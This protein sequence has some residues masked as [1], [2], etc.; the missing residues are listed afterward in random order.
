[1]PCAKQSGGS[2]TTI[3]KPGHMFERIL[4]PLIAT[5]MATTLV[6]LTL[7]RDNGSSNYKATQ[8]PWTQATADNP[9]GSYRFT[10]NGWEESASWRIG[11]EEGKVKFIDQV[12]PL[13]WMLL[14]VLLALG[15]AILASD[16]ETVKSLWSPKI[17]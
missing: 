16:E 13:T 12:H 7:L 2:P 5:L 3:V 1:M 17:Q 9:T 8:P 14:V 6:G 4:I 10:T 15:L 11:G